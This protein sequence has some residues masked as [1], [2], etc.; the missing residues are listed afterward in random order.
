MKKILPIIFLSL[1]LAGCQKTT[2]KQISQTPSTAPANIFTTIQD[3]VNKQLILKC[4]YTDDTGSEIT[5]YIKGSLVFLKGSGDQASV[6]GLMQDHKYY[7][8]ATGNNKG[9]VFDLDK[10]MADGTA[11][12][13]DTV[14]K[15]ED[16][17]IAKLEE[18]KQKCQLSPESASLFELPK[19][20]DF[21]SGDNFFGSSN[22]Q[23]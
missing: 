20:V 1:A 11:K 2:S 17:I 6:S 13:G 22:N 5:T 9:I 4:N 7:I 21:Q 23:K 8:W 15:S 10:M 18:Q 14:I 16:D 19:D 12:M 3:A